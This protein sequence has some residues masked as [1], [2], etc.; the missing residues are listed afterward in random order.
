MET[1]E[2]IH[3]SYEALHGVPLKDTATLGGAF[4]VECDIL[5]PGW[6]RRRDEVDPVRLIDGPARLGTP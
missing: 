3:A 6:R 1:A 4:S 2:S 5:G